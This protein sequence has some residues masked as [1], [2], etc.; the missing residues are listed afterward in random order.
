MFIPSLSQKRCPVCLREKSLNKDI[1]LGHHCKCVENVYI[2]H[3]A[4]ERLKLMLITFLFFCFLG[5][6]TFLIYARSSYALNG[7]TRVFAQQYAEQYKS[8]S[9]LTNVQLLSKAD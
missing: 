6:T 4:L 1:I 5:S 9:A 7:S 8:P 3:L 2:V